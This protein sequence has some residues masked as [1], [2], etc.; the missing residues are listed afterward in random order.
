MYWIVGANGGGSAV[1]V[2][3]LYL[4]WC[5]LKFYVDLCLVE[6]VGCYYKWWRHGGGSDD[7]ASMVRM[8]I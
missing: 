2:V 6:C 1:V 4:W 7:A 8:S 3:V 5:N